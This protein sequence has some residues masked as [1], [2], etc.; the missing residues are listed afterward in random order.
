MKTIVIAGG[1]A[2]GFFAA[3]NIAEKTPGSRVIILEKSSKL[4]EK[5][6]ISGGGRCNTTHAC[7]DPKI[8]TKFYPR[9]EREL[10]SPFMRFNPSNT[11]QWFEKRGV[12]LKKESDGRMFP[13]TNN[14]ETIINCFMQAA[15]KN[16]I[17]ICTNEGLDAL[18]FSAS[19]NLWHIQTGKGRN[20]Q[21]QAVVICS[22]STPRTWQLLSALGH[23]ITP[24]VP[25]LF[26]FNIKDERLKNLAGISLQNATIAIKSLK[27]QETGALLITHWGLSGPAILRLSAWGARSLHQATYKFD[28]SVDFTG[29]GVPA[30]L[31][32]IE[33]YK[34]N[35]PKKT[36]GNSHLFNIPERLWK[37]IISKE[38]QEKKWA[39]ASKKQLLQIVEDIANATFQVSGKSTFK[40]EFVT[41][42]GVHLK[43][44]DFKTMQSK[45]LPH[46]YFAGEVLDIDAITGG[47]NFQAAWTTA[48][49]V[50]E[51]IAAHNA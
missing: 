45:L 39:D 5:V 21:A 28:L 11:I 8:L 20:I 30:I 13:S 33:A 2:A 47:F 26:T 10:L 19:Q 22:G 12:H 16:G 40:D 42:G 50:S 4:L 25:S 6:R 51:S 32:L 46:L 29:M 44:V 38:T 14:S 18:R 3:I 1:G 49:I 31:P 34:S 24:S 41:A 17:E 9:G 43:E 15:L 37:Q 7:F 27:L 36:I 23:T 35:N 48:W